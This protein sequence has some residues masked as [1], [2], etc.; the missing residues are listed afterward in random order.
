M[1]NFTNQDFESH[2]EQI[3]R[4]FQAGEGNGGGSLNDLVTKV[5]KDLNL[6]PEQVSRLCKRVNV[7]NFE[8]KF[9]AMEGDKN[10][11]FELAQPEQVVA[12]LF[13]DAE[14]KT[15][16]AADLYPD[17]PKPAT[18]PLLDSVKLASAEAHAARAASFIPATP[19]VD[20]LY[21]R[22]RKMTD[23]LEGRAKQADC[24]WNSAI[25]EVI[26]RTK[27]MRWDHDTFEKSAL[28]LVGDAALPELE[29][30]RSALGMPALGLEQTKVAFLVDRIDVRPTQEALLIKRAADARKSCYE[31]VA[32]AQTSAE[33][34]DGYHA[35][36]KE[37]LRG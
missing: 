34:R 10:V 16:E 28:C 35:K 2:A 36:L 23:V 24:A 17:L 33:V 22:A 1:P 29:Q 12:T 32:A 7:K 27:G 26:G 18:E 31:N 6:T 14:I 20:I 30:V 25:N 8:V 21:E 15:A 5:A 3:T 4:S 19:P 13:K 37:L 11:K 9:A